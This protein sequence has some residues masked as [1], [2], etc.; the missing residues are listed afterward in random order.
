MFREASQPDKVAYYAAMDYGIDSNR[1][2]D[3]QDLIGNYST[4]N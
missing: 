1:T 3:L 4:A 2:L